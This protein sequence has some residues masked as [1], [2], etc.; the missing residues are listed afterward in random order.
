MSFQWLTFEKNISFVEIPS[1]VLI[2]YHNDN[3]HINSYVKK[4]DTKFL[5][6]STM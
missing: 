1:V 2:M 5:F 6:C 3:I 4:C